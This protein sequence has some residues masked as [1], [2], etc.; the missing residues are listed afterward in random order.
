MPHGESPNARVPERNLF[1]RVQ[2]LH[3]I[4]RGEDGSSFRV[5]EV[6]GEAV[7]EEYARRVAF[8]RVSV[9]TRPRRRTFCAVAPLKTTTEDVFRDRPP[10]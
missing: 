2:G 3:L 9:R 7:Q 6:F 10:E 1:P 8:R 4:V 5:H